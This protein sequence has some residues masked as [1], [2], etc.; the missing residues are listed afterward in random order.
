VKNVADGVIGATSQQYPLLMA[1]MGMEAIKA[2]AESGKKPEKTP[3]L[4]FFNTGVTLITDKP[5][6]GVP[7]ID[8]KEGLA[9]CW[10]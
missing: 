5:V 10:G 1:S 7:S 4:D 3:G 2:F 8:T 9:K 6:D